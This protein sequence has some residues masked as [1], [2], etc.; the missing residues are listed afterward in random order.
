MN[1]RPS[2]VPVD[3]L[4]VLPR[5]I[6]TMLKVAR[7]DPRLGVA[8]RSAENAL[9][10]A[11]L[12]RA[13]EA[14][15]NKETR[16]T[17]ADS[18]PPSVVVINDKDHGFRWYSPDELYD[19]LVETARS[20]S[21]VWNM[22]SPLADGRLWYDFAS[23]PDVLARTVL[24][25]D[26]DQLRH[27]GV[28]LR[29]E[30]S[31]ERTLQEFWEQLYTKDLS[32]RSNKDSPLAQLT[33][34]KAV[35]VCFDGG[36]LYYS[37]DGGTG[38]QMNEALRMYALA[39]KSP[40]AWPAHQ[41]ERSGEMFGRDLIVATAIAVAIELESLDGHPVDLLTCIDYGCRL[42]LYLHHAHLDAGYAPP[43]LNQAMYSALRPEPFAWLFRHWFETHRPVPAVSTTALPAEA[44]SAAAPVSNPAVA[45]PSHDGQIQSPF[46][47]VADRQF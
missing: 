4:L 32:R 47:P 46:Q 36:V 23:N 44:Q 40:N 25:V 16:D 17:G 15:N 42:S 28:D 18:G 39:P 12:W 27:A 24:I 43:S 10:Y 33:D 35:V 8:H 13:F 9:L 1:A 5:A 34:C 14:T 41:P 20:A 19:W 3:P 26:E 7:T 2:T 38:G 21:I 22:S 29:R 45:N 11:Y 37:H 31:S 6:R 30:G